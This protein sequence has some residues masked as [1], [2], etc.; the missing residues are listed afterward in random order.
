MTFKFI[1]FI[2]KEVLLDTETNSLFVDQRITSTRVFYSL[3]PL[4]VKLVTF[5]M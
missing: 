3:L 5:L 2:V 1:L 4:K